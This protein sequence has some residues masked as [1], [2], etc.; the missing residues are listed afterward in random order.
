M[1]IFEK[2]YNGGMMGCAA[3][4]DWLQATCF[5][6]DID[7][8]HHLRAQYLDRSMVIQAD[9]Y[10]Q[11]SAKMTTKTKKGRPKRLS[12]ADD[13]IDV[14][15]AHPTIQRSL[16]GYKHCGS[17]RYIKTLPEAANISHYRKVFERTIQLDRH[18][19]LIHNGRNHFKIKIHKLAHFSGSRYRAL[20]DAL[21]NCNVFVHK[22]RVA[23]PTAKH[24]RESMRNIL[25]SDF[26][27]NEFEWGFTFNAEISAFVAPALQRSAVLTLD[28]TSY[29]YPPLF[30]A[31]SGKNKVIQCKAKIY[32]IS[33]L[34]DGRKDKP[35]QY[36]PGDIFKFEVT[37]DPAFFQS[38]NH[39]YAAEIPAFKLQRDI[40][41]LLLEDNLSQFKT[42][43][44]G[45]LTKT[46][47]RRL[48]NATD[49]NDEDS[50]MR[51][52]S[53]AV[54]L[55][56][57]VDADGQRI[58][59]RLAALEK[60]HYAHYAEFCAFRDETRDLMAKQ[61]SHTD[62]RKPRIDNPIFVH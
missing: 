2:K 62:M 53:N 31:G 46:E 4:M 59:E 6:F 58:L 15:D 52:L 60:H 1:G 38:E 13:F 56:T 23:N 11:I 36:I 34:Q 22:A 39:K 49:T 45:N 40:F 57:H 19:V 14:M 27:L 24:K 17:G 3:N 8:I 35:Y 43:V 9:D 16:S 30:E 26:R 10:L 7:N 47:E 25:K 51:K 32:N 41:N 55:Q 54:S 61:K 5:E 33:A 29:L 42:H 20:L 21:I 44:I 18:T 28:G 50:F 37:Y 48:F 12:V